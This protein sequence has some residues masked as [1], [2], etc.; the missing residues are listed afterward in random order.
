MNYK[1][2]AAIAKSMENYAQMLHNGAKNMD[3]ESI[4]EALD[5]YARAIERLGKFGVVIERKE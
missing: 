1:R 4:D 5:G 3:Q 2:I